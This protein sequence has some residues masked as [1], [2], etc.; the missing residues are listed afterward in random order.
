MNILV[1]TRE[2]PPIGGGAGHVALNLAIN[3]AE[4]GHDIVIV[5]MHFGDLP[6]VE[7]RGKIVIHRVRCGR[8]N[9]DSSYLLEMLRFLRRARPLVRKL[10]AE[11]NCDLIHA[12]AILPD[13]LIGSGFDAPLVI[14]AHGSDVPG[15]NPDNFGLAHRVMAP[16][17]QR[18]LSRAAALVT[19]SRSLADLVESK[20]PSQQIT[21]IPNGIDAETFAATEKQRS[22]L[23]CSRLVRRK[24]YHSFLEALQ[25][26]DLPQTVHIV[27]D[28]PELDA[29]KAMATA[30]PQHKIQFHGWLENGSAEWR[31]LYER[32]LFFVFPSDNENFP[33]NLLEAQLAGMVVLASPIPANKEVLGDNAVY[34]DRLSPGSIASRLE[35]LISME[36]ATLEEIGARA[37]SRVIGEF[38]WSSVTDR[39]LTQYEK[40]IA[41]TATVTSL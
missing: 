6:P 18:T 4:R 22:F 15:Y 41:R 27:G 1:I 26:L 2:I 13:G 33:I 7:T 31:R 34:L 40:A 25:K 38:S 19:P 16:V 8:K 10:L 17:W 12:H 3:L 5:T 20:R 39:Y 23:I 28:G 30:C 21:V 9:Q 36:D 11:H 32:C 14:T 37:R 29:L 24:N 35:T